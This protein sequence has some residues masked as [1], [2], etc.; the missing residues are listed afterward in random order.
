MDHPDIASKLLTAKDYDYYNND[1]NP[2]DDNNHGSH[3][4]GI[5]A[6]KLNNAVGIA[7]IA[8][9]NNVISLKVCS[10]TGSCPVFAVANGVVH[11]VIKN[12]RVINMSLGWK[13]NP[14]T[15]KSAVDFAWNQGV[16]VVVSS[17]NDNGAYLIKY[18]AA[19]QSAISVAATGRDDIWAS[20]STRHK[21]VEV[22]ASGGSGGSV[23]NTRLIYSLNN[24]GGY[25]WMRGTSMATPQVTGAMGLYFSKY[26][27][28]TAIE[29]RGCLHKTVD[30]KAPPGWDDKHGWGR[31]DVKNFLKCKP[32]GKKVLIDNT[33]SNIAVSN[34]NTFK[35]STIRG[36]KEDLEAKGYKVYF[37]SDVGGFTSLNNYDIIILM[38]PHV[39]YS[40][41]EQN[42]VKSW[43][44]TGKGNKLIGMC[45][46]GGFNDNAELNSMLT[47]AGAAIACANKTVSEPSQYDLINSW[48][49]ITNF[50]S[51]RVNST[52]R[53]AGMYAGTYM[54]YNYPTI[55]EAWT[56]SNATA[57]AVN[58]VGEVDS[59]G[60]PSS[61]G[62]IEFT[63]DSVATTYAIAASTRISTTGKNGYVFVIGDTNIWS[64]EGTC[65]TG[66]VERSA[67]NS[68]WLDMVM[69][70]Q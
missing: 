52:M 27:A 67:D 18:P 29:A 47:T 6:A 32:L 17:G 59:A 69:G 13:S 15:L 12:V 50:R 1:N 48:P 60:N 54:I 55:A 8:G 35:W 51:H 4:A 49:I 3:V 5:A 7:G 41:I 11:A 2:Q 58:V 70:W 44:R 68:H 45:E 62:N 14:L 9:K 16:V 37:T 26:S 61:E 20:Y 33:H 56:T 34:N 57:S 40:S 22:S 43:L 31:L 42:R 28:A 23:P 38:D 21:T 10:S 64:T 30:P 25:M 63:P 53:E 65:T 19:Y 36:F 39:A 66:C 46:W 24:S